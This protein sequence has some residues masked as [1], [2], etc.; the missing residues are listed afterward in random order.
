MGDGG[1]NGDPQSRSQNTQDLLGKVLR[2]DVD[3]GWPYAIPDNPFKKEGGRPEIYATGFKSQWRFSFD[4]Q[5][6]SFG[7][8]MWG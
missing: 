6:E 8:P 4:R 3:A 7:W 1:G 2:I 5:T